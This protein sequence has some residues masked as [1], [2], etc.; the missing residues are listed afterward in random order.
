MQIYEPS[1][2][3]T[4][5]A[6]EDELTR[7]FLCMRDAAQDGETIVVSLD[8]DDV[9]GIGGVA[10]AA[11]A[12]GLLGLARALAVEGQKAGWQVN[13][14]SSTAATPPEERLR[15]IEHL[16]LPGAANGELVRLGASHLGRV[17]T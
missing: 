5:E 14:L 7:A 4:L 13:A 12:H 8:E 16:A 10:H 11:L 9:Q 1:T 17:P 2:K 15:W 3:V 6:L